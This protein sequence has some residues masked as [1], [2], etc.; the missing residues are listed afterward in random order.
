MGKKIFLL[1]VLFLVMIYIA[2]EVLIPDFASQEARKMV[3]NHLDDYETL[4]VETGS[5]PAISLLWQ[6]AD[7]LV[8]HGTR[9]KADDLLIDKF[10]ARYEEVR[11]EGE[12]FSGNLEQLRME[13]LASDLNSFLS[14]YG[15]ELFIEPGSVRARTPIQILGRE[16]KLEVNGELEIKG[17]QFLV[18]YP[19]G[20]ILDRVS[21]PGS[22]LEE[23]LPEVRFEIDLD[24]FPF[25]FRVEDVK[26]GDGIV[27]LTSGKGQ[28][29]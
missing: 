28:D 15:V 13:I 22:L 2:G 19:T 18:F 21:I 26:V 5:A 29:R 12:G 25:P 24:R 11:P 7:F 27:L 1:V 17:E 20:I 14:Q 23:F 6:R 4:E 9:L 3:I 16:I 8:I 10:F